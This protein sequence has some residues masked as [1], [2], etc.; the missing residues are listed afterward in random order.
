[1]KYDVVF[2][3]HILGEVGRT[4]VTLK[5]FLARVLLHVAGHV[6]SRDAFAAHGTLGAHL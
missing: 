3:V 6:L 1:M 4:D 2:E 5:L